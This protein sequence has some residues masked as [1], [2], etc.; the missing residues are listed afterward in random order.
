MKGVPI[1]TN[2]KQPIYQ[3]LIKLILYENDV[4]LLKFERS[5]VWSICDMFEV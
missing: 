3:T 5:P 2:F 4:K 1:I